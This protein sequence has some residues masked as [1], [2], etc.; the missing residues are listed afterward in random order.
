MTDDSQ[1]QTRPRGARADAAV[2]TTSYLLKKVPLLRLTYQIR[3]LTYR[4]EQ[5]V[6]D[7]LV[8][9]HPAGCELSPPLERFVREHPEALRIERV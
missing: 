8:L 9:R 7:Q 6:H 3:L 1:P 2:G 5:V 4:A